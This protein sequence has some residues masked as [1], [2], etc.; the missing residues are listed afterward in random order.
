MGHLGIV[1]DS[2]L[3]LLPWDTKTEVRGT[4]AQNSV[5][6]I[7]WR[8]T[9]EQ[10]KKEFQDASSWVEGLMLWRHAEGD[11]WAHVVEFKVT[12]GTGSGL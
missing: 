11:S 3:P 12:P 6:R 4:N 10:M 5:S 2:G 1:R 7:V 9:V 8:Q